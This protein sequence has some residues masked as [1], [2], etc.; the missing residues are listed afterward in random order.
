MRTGG[1][2]AEHLGRLSLVLVVAVGLTSCGSGS[3]S[4]TSPSPNELSR[5]VCAGGA[6]KVFDGPIAVRDERNGGP[7]TAID[8][9]EASGTVCLAIE[10]LPGRAVRVTGSMVVDGERHAVPTLLETQ[11]INGF[12]NGGR[13]YGETRSAWLFRRSCGETEMRRL[14]FAFGEATVEA[15]EG[16][17][18]TES[19]A[20]TGCGGY[21]IDA[22]LHVPD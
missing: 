22:R 12:V 21:S 18:I 20:S 13:D 1:E 11:D 5:Q 16:V 15:S 14:V 19:G 10:V 17:W 3:E 6:G 4:P 9:A 2:L 7:A 8:P